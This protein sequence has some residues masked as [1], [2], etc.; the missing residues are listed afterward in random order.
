MILPDERHR[1]KV[2]EN[3]EEIWRKYPIS[4]ITQVII[5]WSVFLLCIKSL[6]RRRKTGMSKYIEQHP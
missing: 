6:R 3:V 1:A 4:E 2:A 5:S